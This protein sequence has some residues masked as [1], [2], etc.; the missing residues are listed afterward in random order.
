MVEQ[1]M[2]SKTV[3]EILNEMEKD[4]WYVKL[5]REIKLQI[6]VYYCKIFRSKFF[7]KYFNT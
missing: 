6:W 1:N 4:P 2:R 7:R 3:Q 5:K